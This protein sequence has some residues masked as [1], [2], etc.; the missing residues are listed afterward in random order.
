LAV[1]LNDLP[2]WKTEVKGDV[3]I[4]AGKALGTG[5]R[6]FHCDIALCWW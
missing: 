5:F 3:G 4:A 2:V 1:Y 6:E